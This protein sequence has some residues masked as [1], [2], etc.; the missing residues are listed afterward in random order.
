MEGKNLGGTVLAGTLL[1]E[2]QNLARFFNSSMAFLLIPSPNLKVTST[3]LQ[4]SPAFASEF[5]Y[6]VLS[7]SS[8]T[9]SM[10]TKI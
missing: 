4:T 2:R 8:E 1:L 9:S 3:I 5:C 10:L 7:G 6:V